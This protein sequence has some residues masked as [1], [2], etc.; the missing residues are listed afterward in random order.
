M[1]VNN[2]IA[3][4]GLG[5]GL[6]V[7]MIAHEYAHAR[8]SVALG[9]RTPRLYGR[10]TLNPKAHI[11][12]LGTIILPAIF[13]L[14]VLVGSPLRLMFGWAKPVP[15][16]P[17]LLR[18][19]RDHTIAVALA[20]PATNLLIAA[21]AGVGFRAATGTNTRLFL[22]WVV[23]VNVFLFVINALPIPPLDGSKVLARFLSPSAAQKME[24]IGQYGLLFLLLFF[25]F[26]PLAGIL[27]GLTDPLIDVLTGLG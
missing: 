13:V 21:V 5:L 14:S 24:E 20:G 10:L 17:R 6:L 15:T 3:A 1:S 9:D 23:V 12:P 16:N 4:V 22:F 19:P 25:I 7:G 26:P 18:N 27:T 2:L 8:V 11:D